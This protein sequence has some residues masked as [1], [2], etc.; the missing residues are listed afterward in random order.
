MMR[1]CDIAITAGLAHD[2]GALLM[3]D[4]TFAS[5][6]NQRPLELG[7]DVVMHSTTKYLNGHSD[8][9][10]GM[11]VANDD[12]LAEEIRFVRKSTGAVPGPMDAWL[13][14]RG[15]KTLHV[16]MERHN[17]NGMAVARFLEGHAGVDRVLYPGLES[18]PQHLLARR[19]MRGFSGMV[20]VDVGDLRRAKALAE[21][22]KIFQLAESLGG[23]ESLV[24]V[25]AMMTHASVPDEL[26]KSMGLTP[27]IVRLSVGIEDVDD[28]VA[29]LEGAFEQAFA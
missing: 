18:H 11:L 21:S 22:L 16:R 15:A 25:P 23:V 13:C 29:D 27:G 8:I 4:N 6:F 9:I 28:L 17:A 7:A 19:Q 3:V 14:L 10:G 24:C 26:K 12:A 2:I 20:S 1:L 5:P